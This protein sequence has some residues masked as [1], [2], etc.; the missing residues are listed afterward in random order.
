[1]NNKKVKSG[2]TLMELMVYIGLLGLIVVIAGRAFSD[3]SRMRMRTQSML[4]ASQT[5]G[6]V[7]TI[8]KQ[9]IAQLGAKSAKITPDPADTPTLMD[10]FDFKDSVY[11]KIDVT[12][13]GNNDSSSFTIKKGQGD[14]EDL[15]SLIMRR[16][17]YSDAGDYEAVEEVSWYVDEDH[18]L[19]RSCRVVDIKTGVSNDENCPTEG[20]GSVAI[21]E[22]VAK[23][24]LTAATPAV[25][26]SLVSVLPSDVDS[27]KNFKLV[28]RFGDSIYEPLNANPE[29]GGASITLSGFYRNYDFDESNPGPITE[30]D[31]I[32]ANQVFV[33]DPGASTHSWSTQC[34]KITLEPYVEYEISFSM[35]P[36]PEDDASRMFCPGRDH[37]AVGFRFADG[38]R[39]GKKPDG[40]YDFQFY[41]PTE[42]DDTDTGLRKMRFVA[43]DTLKNVCLGFSFALFSPVASA[44][45]INISDLK[46]K[47]VPT[48][49]YK[50]VNGS[51][52][53]TPGSACPANS[54][55]C[56]PK[57][58]KNV[59]AIKVEFSIAKNG[60]SGAETAIIPIPSNGPRD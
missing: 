24:K 48:S 6:N 49:N 16:V 40:L 25:A 57:V 53:L 51:C 4:Q 8:I 60:E 43:N 12:N 21:A 32:K 46:L 59:K 44:G 27:V 37:M 18:V 54:P 47:K 45:N 33:A 41:P 29:D 38:T 36:P 22:S 50:F 35:P 39:N 42:G 13:A 58:K 14:S 23:F 17:R 7:A 55:C 19:W 9:D 20:V 15:D 52:Y 3:S 26:D 30:P 11:M 31:N 34:H 28:A 2:F 1:M 56:D 5:S 10:E